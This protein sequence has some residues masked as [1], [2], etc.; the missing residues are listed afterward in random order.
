MSDQMEWRI[1]LGAHKTAT[2]HIQD[3]LESQKAFL[4]ENDIYY[5]T[6]KQF[7]DQKILKYLKKYAR[8]YFSLAR[9]RGWNLA[10]ATEMIRKGMNSVIIS[11]ENIIGSSI[12]LLK[13]PLYPN[14]DENLAALEKS[15]GNDNVILYVSIRKYSEILISAYAQALRDGNVVGEISDY[16][17]LYCGSKYPNWTD[18]VIRIRKAFPQARLHVWDMEYYSRNKFDLL[19]KMAGIPLSRQDIG[20]SRQTRTP[21]A[22]SIAAARA[23]NPG[24]SVEVRR[25]M[26]A[27]I[28]DAD[29][30]EEKYAPLTEAQISFL[31][32]R[33]AKEI[34]ALRQANP[35]LFIDS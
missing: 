12:D 3:L 34:T 10:Q 35:D 32:T 23:I 19:E 14:I 33:Y 29:T 8:S 27:A 2:T 22:A 31:D 11:E 13:Y 16:L 15:I 30:Y 1:H 17:D 18:A 7:R 25:S 24:L 5:I 21:S 4:A 20:I 6:R 26:A 9:L 28:F